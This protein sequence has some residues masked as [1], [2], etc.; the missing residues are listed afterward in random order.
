MSLRK[1]IGFCQQSERRFIIESSYLTASFK[2]LLALNFTD[3]LAA[4][5]IFSFVAGLIPVRAP[6]L[7]VCT[8]NV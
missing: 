1:G 8:M 4:I 7:E 2:D 5:S 6:S 3:L